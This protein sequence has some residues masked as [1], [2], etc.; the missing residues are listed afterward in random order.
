MIVDALKWLD[1]KLT[2]WIHESETGARYC[3]KK[4]QLLEQPK[5]EPFTGETLTGLVDYI[6]SDIDGLSTSG[7]ITAWIKDHCTVI[8]CGFLERPYCIRK[9]YVRAHFGRGCTG[10]FGPAGPE[11][12]II[13][14]QA[15]YV[16]D[17]T[18]AALL[19][20]V[21]NIRDENVANFNDDGVT[22]QVT[23][24]VGLARV[25]NVPLQNAIELR[26]FRTFAEIEQPS[27]TFIL[28][29]Q[30]GSAKGEV[31]KV[32]LKQAG[33]ARWVGKAISDIKEYLK[34]QLPHL[35]VIA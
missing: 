30:S 26:P 15:Q 1:E 12:A 9:E 27:S 14:L 4:L 11:E 31:P 18:T 35:V 34:Q 13:R 32:M 28:R 2:P 24:R 16:Q 17:A 25:E 7:G 8:L 19:R 10:E 29:M 21:G 23:V 5:P 6:K 3:N 22:Q 33:D 20:L